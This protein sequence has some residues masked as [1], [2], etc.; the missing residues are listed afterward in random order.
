[1]EAIMAWLFLVVMHT[2][3]TF[4]IQLDTKEQCAE[5]ALLSEQY[6]YESGQKAQGLCMKTFIV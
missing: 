5:F 1:M 6:W 2:T 3:T 4:V